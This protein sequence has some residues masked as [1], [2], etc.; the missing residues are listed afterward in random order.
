VLQLL[1]QDDLGG[2][3]LMLAALLERLDRSRIESELAI[4]SPPGPIAARLRDA[5]L[6]IHDL[7]GRSL[8][9][10]GLHL[11]RLLRRRGF[12]VLAA[13]GLRAGLLGRFAANAAAPKTKVVIGVRG[14]LTT[15]VERTDS[16]KARFALLAE[17][18]T[19]WMVDVY[20]ANSPG[21]GELL[22]QS[23]VRRDR[24][25]YIPNGIDLDR[26]ARP[27][28]GRSGTGVPLIVS[29]A[30]FVPRKRQQDLLVALSLLAREGVSF[31]AVL[32][33]AGP[34]LADCQRFA[35]Q[36]GLEDRVSFPGRLDPD[37]VAELL[38]RA[39]VACL[40]SLWEGMPGF[41]MEAMAAGLPVVATNV[42]GSDEL[43]LDG[44]TGYLVPAEDPEA[45]KDTLG[46]IISDPLLAARLGVAGRERIK[47][48]Y[49]LDAMVEA[50]QELYEGVAAA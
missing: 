5:G 45:L 15:E 10:Q 50:K 40:S 42:N 44:S 29:V 26:W 27:N 11:G 48:E 47:R 9:G 43:V 3:E 36:L 33:G 37:A 14:L 13:Y 23:G 49:S 12:D 17:R 31:N 28:G 6:P 30:R 41:I 20:D 21:A 19:S 2:T 18:L 35:G 24:I 8:A 22:A 7:G 16:P 39:E 34:T 1:S 4:L 25:R 38:G 46:A 32:A